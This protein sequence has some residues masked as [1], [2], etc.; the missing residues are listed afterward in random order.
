MCVD[1]KKV[2]DLACV[3]TI[4]KSMDIHHYK[5]RNL[6]KGHNSVRSKDK[7]VSLYGIKT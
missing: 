4:G 5:G 2:N 7:I 3:L 1:Y 6:T